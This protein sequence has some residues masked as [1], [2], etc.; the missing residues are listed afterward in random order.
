M[1]ASSPSPTNAWAVMKDLQFALAIITR[2]DEVE[3]KPLGFAVKQA[4]FASSRV[5]FAKVQGCDWA[6]SFARGA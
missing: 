1:G 2:V 5:L 6:T 3:H 4:R